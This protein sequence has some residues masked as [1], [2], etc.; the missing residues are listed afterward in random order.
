MKSAEDYC[1]IQV[2]TQVRAQVGLKLGLRLG[3]QAVVQARDKH[4]TITY[5]IF[6]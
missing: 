1:R 4:E 2:R 6:E 5:E 3:E